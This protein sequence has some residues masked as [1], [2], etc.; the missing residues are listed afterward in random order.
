M[1]ETN[2][3]CL[4]EDCKNIATENPI[5]ERPVRCTIHKMDDI[6]YDKTLKYIRRFREIHGER[7]TYFKTYYIL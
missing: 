2:H 1:N 4:N 6:L 3:Y 5:E 7:Y